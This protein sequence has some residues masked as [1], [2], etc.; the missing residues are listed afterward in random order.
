MTWEGSGSSIQEAGRL[1]HDCFA[2]S[3][4][5]QY[6]EDQKQGMKGELGLQDINGAA[7]TILI[8]CFDTTNTTIL[9]GILALLLQPA[10]FKKA[11]E[12]LDRVIGPDRLPCIKDREN[13]ELR[14]ID[15]IVEI[16]RW[17]PLSP[18]GVPHMSLE[19]DNYRDMVIPGGS[20]VLFNAWAM[21]RDRDTYRD[22]EVFNPERYLS[23]EEGDRESR[24]YRRPLGLGGE[25]VRGSSLRT[26][27]CG[28]R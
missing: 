23:A 9:V 16:S 18:L 5:R 13:L 6:H 1:R 3:L 2:Y 11:R 7:A 4:L 28:L 20:T 12:I 25:C 14:Y 17:R 10:V 22:P 8:V 21:S 24:V 19:D 27:V 15:C 26:Q